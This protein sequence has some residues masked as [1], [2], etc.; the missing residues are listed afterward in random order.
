[1][2]AYLDM[3]FLPVEDED[4]SVPDGE[5]LDRQG[6][7]TAVGGVI[8]AEAGNGIGIAG[9]AW[10]SDLMAVRAGFALTTDR[11]GRFGLLESDDA[12]SALRWA[13]DHGADVINMSF[14]GA[15]SATL[16][17][18]V[19]YADAMGALQV[20]GAGNGARDA[21][22]SFPASYAEVMSIAALNTQS[23]LAAFSNF[24]QTLNL[25]APGWDILTLRAEGTAL[26]GEN[27]LVGEDY[28]RASGTSLAAPFVSAAAALALSAHPGLTAAALR[29]RLEGTSSPQVLS[30]PTQVGSRS[31]VGAGLPDLYSAVAAAP[32]PAPRLRDWQFSDSIS[33]PGTNGNGLAESGET[34]SLS[35]TLKNVWQAAAGGVPVR[36][37][38]SDPFLEV[39][40][41]EW[42]IPS[43]PEDAIR[44]PRFRL[45]VSP[46]APPLH[47]AHLALVF[48]MGGTET[49]LPLTLEVNPPIPRTVAGSDPESPS[50]YVDLAPAID[51]A[52]SGIGVVAW[53]RHLFGEESV[54]VRAR[55]LAPSGAP[56]GEDLLVRSV[57]RSRVSDIDVSASGGSF[58]VTW[59]RHDPD[60][61]GGEQRFLEGRLF[62]E[63]GSPLSD[64]LSFHHE[65]EGEIIQ[66]PV[67]AMA[68]DGSFLL[69]WETF[70]DGGS[71]V[72]AQRFRAD[73]SA[74]G[75]VFRVDT[76]SFDASESSPS[77][78][79]LEGGGSVIVWRTYPGIGVR[80]RLFDAEGAPRGA[81]FTVHQ[82][83]SPF[84]VE[85]QVA[86][87]TGGGF[88]V[89]WDHCKRPEDGGTCSVRARGFDGDGVAIGPERTVSETPDRYLL[90]ARVAAASGGGGV[91]W[92]G[93]LPG[94]VLEG[95][96]LYFRYLGESGEPQGEVLVTD[97]FQEIWEADLAAGS[98]GFLQAFLLSG[99]S[100][101]R[102]VAQRVPDSR[103]VPRT[104]NSGDPAQLCLQG[105]RFRL[106]VEW[107]DP[108]GRGGQG[109]VLPISDRTGAFWFR[110]PDNLELL[111]KV[112][113]GRS[114][115]GHWWIFYGA[116]SNVEYMLTVDDT[117]TGE[118]RS[119][120]NPP[121]HLASAGET[122]AFEE[123]ENEARGTFNRVGLPGP[124]SGSV[125]PSARST[126]GASTEGDGA[127]E[128]NDEVLCLGGGRFS[129][130]IRWQDFGGNDGAGRAVGLT[131]DTGYFSFFN[132]ANVEVVVKLLDG[133][134]ANGHWWV[135][136]A[137]TSNVR[138]DLTVTDL[139]TGA[140]KVYQNPARQF[141][142]RADIEAF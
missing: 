109:K 123:P 4:Y 59:Q 91:T 107:L 86:A 106:G 30:T 25:V 83:G 119:F 75:S 116:L 33:L 74:A 112:L 114:V 37:E 142:S 36:L 40:S 64:V 6:H 12:A 50:L 92:V 126:T 48:E 101:H 118:R 19:A 134:A 62:R 69:S 44:T 98:E 57:G 90:W 120:R 78:A 95:C 1:L 9:A 121:R 115:N 14:G 122:R 113:D 52:P 15:A 29:R 26:T 103:G 102:I 35:A 38:T 80:A 137:S 53:F 7:G 141:A 76:G 65:S 56:Q 13:A 99:S 23:E 49:V 89:A 42:L 43:M 5:P 127:C 24:G 140:V 27:R 128:G 129:L 139:E 61:E 22:S 84:S 10:G 20:A 72:E 58:I 132:P 41:G 47:L 79:F 71:G 85:P 93:C 131:A 28:L 136:Y 68:A 100:P 73:G 117:I 18:A 31:W 88:L 110:R 51:T 67:V 45:R 70:H 2:Q 3:G 54:E 11:G 46:S 34:L 16:Q 94:F 81:P 104:C 133:R 60:G 111:V 55:I 77:V 96:N 125:R 8:A 130:E 108:G 32:Q 138:F 21:G 97:S 82:E 66:R 17:A 105:G 87:T 135:F 124:G 63:D 39:E